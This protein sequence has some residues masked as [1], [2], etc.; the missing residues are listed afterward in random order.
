MTGPHS[1]EIQEA[2]PP[3]LSDRTWVRFLPGFIRKR[4]ANRHVFQ[5]A[6][7]NSGWL[8]AD[9]ILRMGVGLLVGVWVAR[10]LGPAQYGQISYAGSLIGLAGAVAG[11][12]IDSI[13]FRD[14]VRQPDKSNELLGTTFVLRFLAGTVSYLFV[15]GLIFVLRPDDSIAHAIVAILGLSL[16]VGAFDAIDL[17]FQSKVLSKYVVVARNFGFIVSAI[18]R[19]YLVI[20]KASVISFA[21]ITLVEFSLGALALLYVYARN[22]GSVRQWQTRV[23]VAAELLRKGWP[24][25]LGGIVSMIGLRIDQVMLGQMADLKEVGV[26]AAAVRVAEIWFFIPAAITASVYPNLIR[27]KEVDEAEFYK[28]LQK[29]YNFLAFIG[30]AIAIPVTFLGGVIINLLYGKAYVA[31]APMLVLLIWSNLFINLAIARGTFL[32]AMNWTWVLFWVNV[33]AAVTN[34]ALNIILIPKYGGVGAAVASVLSY[35]VS[36]HIACYLIKP[37]RRTGGM[38]THSLLFPKFW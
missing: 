33:L 38:I 14:L 34:I 8:F 15:V 21:V 7:E 3:P 1:D 9:K 31:A 37:L 4:F 18:G 32:I 5:E 35:W 27:A 25:L 2:T 17:W 16:T 13:V 24:V 22:N 30:Y 11:L 12:G 19:V 28:R 29:L 26:Y 23:T 20:T 6:A 10:Y 36:A